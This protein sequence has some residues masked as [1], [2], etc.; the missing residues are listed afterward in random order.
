MTIKVTQNPH[1]ELEFR[2][3]KAACTK[4]CVRDVRYE[5]VDWIQASQK[6]IMFNYEGWKG[7]SLLVSNCLL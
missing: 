1:S 2:L 5:F 7:S 4:M 6:G 3:Q